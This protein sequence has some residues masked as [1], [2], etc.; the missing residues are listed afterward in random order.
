SSTTRCRRRSGCRPE[1][2][3]RRS[4]RLGST[5]CVA[6][7]RSRSRSGRGSPASSRHE[8]LCRDCPSTLT[9]QPPT[10]RVIVEKAPA[11]LNLALEVVGRRPDGYHE[12]V[13]LFQTVDLSDELTFEPA[14]KLTLARDDPS[15]ARPAT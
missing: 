13:A 6:R 7:R 10:P 14:D 1:A 15:L 8:A 2:L 9:P 12:L 11:K 5:R 3:A 4:R